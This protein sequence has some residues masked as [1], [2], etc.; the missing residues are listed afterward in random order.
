M[1]NIVRTSSF[2]A[3]VKRQIKRGK[4]MTKLKKL[5]TL[6]VNQ[7]EIPAEYE[8][9]QLQG[10]WRGYRDAHMEGDWILIYRVDEDDL[11]LARTGTHQDIFSNY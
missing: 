8:D 1:L 7:D 6:L 2:K 10:N 3:D 4:D 9:H 5:I 11:K